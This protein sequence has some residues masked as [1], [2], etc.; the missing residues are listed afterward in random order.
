MPEVLPVTEAGEAAELKGI[1]EP[2]IL[3]LG[4]WLDE[5][6]NLFSD[7]LG[8]IM[9]SPA[10]S[11]FAVFGVFLVVWWLALRLISAGKAR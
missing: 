2:L 4:E 5:V 7:T 9:S 6:V 3:P 10:L 11:F 1:F 8:L